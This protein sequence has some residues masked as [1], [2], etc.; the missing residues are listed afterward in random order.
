MILVI[1][2]YDSFTY[3]LVQML[4]AAGAKTETVRNDAIDIA[5]IEA[6]KPEA[7]L[8]SPGP[9]DPDSAGVTLEAVKAFAGRMPLFGVC[10][11]HQAIAQAF[12]AR[13][14]PAKRLMHGKTSRLRHDGRGLFAGLDQGFAAM[15]YHSLAVDRASLPDCLE[16]TAESEDGEIMGLRHKTLRIESVQ[17]HPESVGTAQGARQLANLVEMA[18][19]RK[20][21]KPA[22]PLARKAILAKAL[23]GKAPDAAETEGYFAAVMS[24]ETSEVELAA[25]LT[26]LAKMPPTAEALAGAA[27]AMRDAGVKIDLG[28]VDAVDIVGTGGD[29]AGTFNVSTTA[30]FIAAG[31]GVTIAKHGNIAST[32][33]CGSADVLGALGYNLSLSTAAAEKCI[34]E[35]GVGFLFAKHMHP[36]MRFAAPMRRTLG[37]RTVFNLLGPLANPAGAKRQVVGVPEERL[38]MTFAGALASLGSTRSWVVSGAGGL[39]EIGPD[40][41][42]FVSSLEN[43]TVKNMLLDAGGE[44]GERHPVA[45]IKGGD[46]AHNAKLL[47]SVLRG[48]ERG[49]YRAAA[50]ENAAAAIL[51]GEK[52]A[53][54][55]E[56]LA[57][58]RES[59][60][61]GR[62]AEKLEKMIEISNRDG[63][64][65]PA[66]EAS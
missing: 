12:G 49:A 65:G 4:E 7:I 58:A 57:L 11:G 22:T 62:A 59:I 26:A 48:E 46:A 1:D 64:A 17:Y 20:M 37:F 31:A 43:G 39:D 36:A 27:R 15:R 32:S 23:E 16:I 50:V 14:V 45:A 66:K 3:N 18:T 53:G 40:G 10:L 34:R 24:G 44:Y 56:A 5:G 6:L 55:R 29:G 2:N 21:R 52:A 38:A 60:D 42:T 25:F 8:F 47:L 13:I 28:D 41:F 54:Y 35:A 61:S 19:G 63:G 30:A 51:V 33:A 9:G